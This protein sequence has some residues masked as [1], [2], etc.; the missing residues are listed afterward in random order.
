M[1]ELDAARRASTGKTAPAPESAAASRRRH[2]FDLWSGQYARSP[3]E[4]VFP[5]VPAHGCKLLAL[6]E[7][8]DRPQLVS[9]TFHF[10]QG[11][12]EVEDARYDNQKRTLALSLRPVAEKEGELILY[13]PSGLRGLPAGVG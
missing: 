1:G 13:A 10:T 8:Q 4:A 5:E 12:L 9:S 2:V 6:R 7:A 3:G 11:A